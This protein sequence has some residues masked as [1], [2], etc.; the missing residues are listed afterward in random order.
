MPTTRGV[1]CGNRARSDRR[2][3]SAGG[4]AVAAMGRFYTRNC[5]R[6]SSRQA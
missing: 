6:C 4:A 2:A 1:Q 5:A 3:L